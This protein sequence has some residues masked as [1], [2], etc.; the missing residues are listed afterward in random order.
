LTQEE[1]DFYQNVVIRDFD[2]NPT[3]THFEVVCPDRD[4]NMDDVRAQLELLHKEFE[5]G[6]VVLDHGQWI[7]PR[8][9]RKNK[10][11]TIELNSV[12]NDSKRLALTF[13]HNAGVPVLMLFQI[14][15]NGKDDA[16]KNDGIYK[17]KALT[18]ANSC[19]TGDTLVPTSAGLLQLAEITTGSMVWSSSGWRKVLAT[20][21]NG[22]RPVVE[23]STDRGTKMRVTEDHRFKTLEAEG[24]TWT[25]AKD[26]CGRYVLCPIGHANGLRP[27]NTRLPRLKLRKWDRVEKNGIPVMAPLKLTTELAYLLGAHAGDGS[28]QAGHVG[29]VGNKAEV[30]VRNKLRATFKKV[31]SQTLTLHHPKRHNGFV[32]V[33]YSTAL[34]RWFVEIGSDRKAGVP[35]CVLRGTSEQMLAF[36]KGFWDTDGHVNTQGNVNIG[37]KAAKRRTLEHVQLMLL[38]F[39]IDSAIH[40][41]IEKLNGKEYP[42]EVLTIRSRRG[43]KLFASLIGFTEPHKQNRLKRFVK[44][45]AGSD[46][47]ASL[48]EWPVADIY[49]RLLLRYGWFT[50]KGTEQIKAYNLFVGKKRP[51]QLRSIADQLYGNHDGNNTRRAYSLMQT[52]VRKGFLKHSS[53]GVYA[54]SIE[55]ERFYFPRKCN[56]ALSKIERRGYPLVSRGAIEDALITLSQNGV[57]GDPDA[58]LLSRLLATVIPQK[59]ISVVPAGEAHVYDLEVTGD[60][61]FAAGGLLVHNCE[62]TADVITSTYLNEEMRAAGL[63]KFCN[64]KNRDNPLF[65]PFQ[66]HVNFV[67]RR[68]LSPKRMEPQGFVVEEFDS[69]L[70]SMQVQL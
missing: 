69:Y 19:I 53:R 64:L 29:F 18:Y 61:E 66:A 38:G 34:A 23:V 47:R 65:E 28:L 63:T 16:D 6:L 62:K 39:G 13:D 60:H 17:L 51:L 5:V 26:L 67:S 56:I 45:Y 31:F 57:L 10:D 36:L 46:R 41:K 32:L 49:R 1:K 40:P 55:R 2:S 22:V 27:R 25:E 37:Q 50:R 20:Y 54:G 52:M 21:A 7:E 24:P 11:Y 30:K 48:E 15:R 43:R 42:Q 35:E 4:W 44:K 59:V 8:K 33:H 12:V 9:A 3:Y 68:I 14:N 58:E 70:Q